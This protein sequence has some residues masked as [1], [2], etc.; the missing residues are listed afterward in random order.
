MSYK[1]DIFL[2]YNSN[3]GVKT[4]VEECFYPNLQECMQ[5][6]WP[7]EPSIYNYTGQ[8]PGVRWPTDVQEALR[9]SKF[10]VCIW[11]PPYFRSHWCI[12]EWK[13]MC[14]RASAACTGHEAFIYPIKFSDGIHFPDDARSLFQHDFSQW[15]LPLEVLKRSLLFIDFYR[16]VKEVVT[17]LAGRLNELPAWCDNWPIV[18]PDPLPAPEFRLP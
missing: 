6:E 18:E 12:A 4:W 9:R 13:S 5:Q 11:A 10:M 8:P 16:A 3:A 15:T 7:S 14:S 17:S 2:S 1:Y